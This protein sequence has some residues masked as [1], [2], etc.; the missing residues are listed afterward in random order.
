MLDGD[1]CGDRSPRDGLHRTLQ[2]FDH[3]RPLQR[4]RNAAED[5]QGRNHNGQRQQH[6]K[7]RPHE[8]AVE[9]A[10]P[11]LASQPPGQSRER[12]EPGGGRHELQPHQAEDLREVAHRDFARVVLQIGVRHE[13]CDR[14]ENQAGLQDPLAVRIERK[15][16]LQRQDRKHNHKHGR[17]EKEHGQRILLPILLF[18]D[19]PAA[20]PLKQRFDALPKS[21]DVLAG[22]HRP[23]HAFG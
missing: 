9:V 20:S 8:V 1:K 21:A 12:R 4:H 11:R 18:A 16:L 6:E 2:G 22:M 19:R 3:G 14:V 13:R 7:R 17:V 5:K 23:E 15:A 10:D